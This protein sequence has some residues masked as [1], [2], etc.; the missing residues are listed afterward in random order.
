[1]VD[2]ACRS[3]NNIFRSIFLIAVTD[4]EIAGK[5][6]HALFVADYRHSQRV[7]MLEVQQGLLAG[8]LEL[9]THAGLQVKAESAG[10]NHFPGIQHRK[11]GKLGGDQLPGPD[12]ALVVRLTCD[13]PGR[14]SF[15][16]RLTRP[17]RFTTAGDSS[18]GLI[19]TGQ[20]DDGR[21][22]TSGMKYMVRLK[23][24]AEGGVGHCQTGRLLLNIDH[25]GNVARCTETLDEPVGNLLTEDVMDLRRRLLERQRR[26]DCSKCWTSCRGFAES[27]HMPPRL[28]QFKEFLV[29]VG[30]H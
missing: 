1:M 29:S 7:T 10:G 11:L 12:Q 13:K 8:R 4:D 2:P 15:T 25:R 24:I 23:A 21:G 18:D 14:I 17:E 3:D 22:G 19:M 9:P 28:R 5:P 16:A 30:D 26:S 20:M 6:P 27:M